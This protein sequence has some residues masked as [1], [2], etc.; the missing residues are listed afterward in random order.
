MSFPPAL[1]DFPIVVALSASILAAVF[2]GTY[3]IAVNT[4]SISAGA[5][6]SATIEF[7]FAKL[8]VY[9]ILFSQILQEYASLD[10]KIVQYIFCSPSLVSAAISIIRRKHRVSKFMRIAGSRVRGIISLWCIYTMLYTLNR[11]Y[12]TAKHVLGVC[13]LNI[14]YCLLLLDE[15][16]FGDATS[17]LS[18]IFYVLLMGFVVVKCLYFLIVRKSAN[19]FGY[20]QRDGFK[21][22]TDELLEHQLVWLLCAAAVNMF[23]FEVLYVVHKGN[24]FETPAVALYR[25]VS[26]CFFAVMFCAFTGRMHLRGAAEVGVRI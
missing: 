17:T 26:D 16:T 11:R 12:W 15:S 13:M 21:Y 6:P 22:K 14:I 5:T 18:I 2:L 9:L 8:L 19:A 1:S 23:S 24:L 10:L 20:Q 25:A 3:Y 7:Q 4:V